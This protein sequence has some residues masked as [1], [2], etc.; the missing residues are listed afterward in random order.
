[1]VKGGGKAA[2]RNKKEPHPP[3]GPKRPTDGKAASKNTIPLKLQQL[4]LDLFRDAFH[5][6]PEDH[7]VLQEIKGYL[8][9]RDFA[10]AF[11]KDEY[12]RV[13]ASRWSPS[14]ALAYV[15][16]FQDIEPYLSKDSDDVA[17]TVCIGGGAGGELVALSTLSSLEHTGSSGSPKR[18]IVTLLDIADWSNV[19]ERLQRTITKPPE[20]SKYASQAKKDANKALLTDDALTV[21]FKKRDILDSQEQMAEQ[22]SAYCKGATLVTFMFT[23][24]ELYSTSMIKTQQLL[25]QL[26]DNMTPGSCLLVV[27]SPGS[28]STVSINGA[29]KK[30]PMQWLLDYTLLGQSTKGEK[31]QVPPQWEKL[32]SHDSRWF[33]LDESLQYPIELEDMRYQIHLYRRLVDTSKK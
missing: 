26:T 31:D 23:L 28:Y 24:N 2:G 19:I 27:D 18:T 29:E 8:Y 14:R 5:P 13:Y 11:G 21:S 20:L 3:T 9:S 30:Y 7:R 10:A 32:T 1:M 15:H 17:H 25:Q 16:V 6:G 22:L 4:C 33:R 12:L